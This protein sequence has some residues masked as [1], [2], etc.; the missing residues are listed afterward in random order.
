M[1][2]VPTLRI[3]DDSEPRAARLHLIVPLM[4]AL[5]LIVML[6]VIFQL[7]GPQ[8]E[9]DAYAT[10][11][12]AARLKTHQ[13]EFWFAERRGDGLMIQS[14]S[15]LIELINNFQISPDTKTRAEL[16]QRIDGLRHDGVYSAVAVLNSRGETL[17][18]WGEHHDLRAQTLE[19]LPQLLNSG[20][21][22]HSDPYLEPNDKLPAIDFIVPL[23]LKAA[24]VE[25]AVAVLVL[26]TEP[27]RSM[28][29]TVLEWP[30]ASP[31]GE[32]MLVRREGD[33]VV[34]LNPLRHVK[35]TAL[36]LSLSIDEP[37][38][39]AAMALRA[40]K[41][42]RIR[43][44]DYRGI[45]VLSFH[46]P[47]AGTDWQ[48]VTKIDY[49]EVMAPMKDLLTWVAL[50]VLVATLGMAALLRHN[51]VQREEAQRRATLFKHA[52]SL[53]EGE[54]RFLARYT[55][56]LSESEER[57]YAVTETARDAI[58]TANSD[59]NIVTWNSAAARMFGYASDEIIGQ[60]MALIIPQRFRQRGMDGLKRMLNGDPDHLNGGVAQLIGRCKDDSEVLLDRSV[61]LWKTAADRFY[62][63][64]MRDIGDH[65][66]LQEKL[67]LHS[68]ALEAASNAIII[69][70]ATGTI[71]W[72]NSSFCALSGCNMEEVLSR[73]PWEL[74][75]SGPQTLDVYADMWRD[76]LAGRV[77]RGEVTIC[78]KDGTHY[79]VYQTT[80][81]IRNEKGAVEH[82]ITV[83]QDITERR[84]QE[85]IIRERT[86]QVDAIFDL[87]PDG[88]VSF[89]AAHCIKYVSPAFARLT[90]LDEGAMMGLDADE[91]SERLASIC[92]PAARFPGFA[93]LSDA[94]GT[95]PQNRQTIELA[96]AEK[97][98]LQVGLRLSEA[99]TVSQILYFRDITH[100]TEVG[101]LK[102][103]FLA[104]AAHELRTPMSSIFGFTELLMTQE[105]DEAD[106]ADFLGTI[107]RQSELMICI[108]NE[109]LDLARIEAR[110]GQD[111]T[112]E[113]IDIRT[114]LHEIVTGFKT[115]GARPVLQGP[116]A[117]GPLWV[118]A[119]RQKLIQ[120]ISN[121]ISNAC[122]Y[123]PGGGAVGIELV[124][125]TSDVPLLGIRITDHGIGMTPEQL[126]R[127]CERFYRADAS[128]K[129]RAQGSA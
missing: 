42:G 87:S 8:L 124:P 14:D 13:V 55:Q 116:P 99:E 62:T 41:A 128:G 1:T 94:S 117:D 36:K 26:H 54:A 91:F 90:G 82:F 19:Q 11:E 100:E 17:L 107:F 101:R 92:Q 68:A 5:A 18:T 69:T 86:A 110:R 80:T 30:T 3:D 112:I 105:L 10:L 15:A 75:K 79:E 16:T 118:G 66:R 102:S 33:S 50:V 78:R 39:T 6:G 25:R 31:S 98:V 74:V 2:P 56:T 96:G 103:E 67:R 89:D 49:D 12:I 88:F 70:D 45:D 57:L 59:G 46:Q 51:W 95:P 104:H 27:M 63:C 22:G 28:F 44:R 60:S 43:G 125:P 58:V 53:S 114:L 37:L 4:V 84:M 129:F 71:E 81:P 52:Q 120:A 109:L 24:G 126:A 72:A 73:K 34:L 64:T 121:V 123:S 76:I 47:V 23:K 20:K 77:G 108:I 35:D 40:G 83:Q 65:K 93:A 113:R 122:K 29:L 38:L 97:R 21:L 32:N 85:L 119:D 61:A 115:P 106:R 127:V 7:K 9:S 48:L 111:F